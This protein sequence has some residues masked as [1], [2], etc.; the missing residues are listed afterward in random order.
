MPHNSLRQ[1]D[2]SDA[3][4][5]TSPISHA[6]NANKLHRLNA[7]KGIKEELADNSGLISIPL[8][9]RGGSDGAA[10]RQPGA[11]Q[12]R[13]EYAGVTAALLMYPDGRETFTSISS[14]RLRR[15]T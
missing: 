11:G 14:E 5:S 7:R 13:N 9:I 15:T 4:Y 2:A 1:C 12:V 10:R 6:D 3:S 8:A